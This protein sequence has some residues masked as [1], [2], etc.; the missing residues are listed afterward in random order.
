VAETIAASG[1]EAER[2]QSLTDPDK[3]RARG[4]T[5]RAVLA[6]ATARHH[7]SVAEAELDIDYGNSPIVMGDRHVA[8]SPG[9]RLPDTIEIHLVSGEA[10]MLPGLFCRAGHTAVILGGLCTA[11]GSHDSTAPIRL[12]RVASL[13]E[14]TVVITARPEDR[15]PCAWIAPDASNQLGIGEIT[16]L[17]VR[18]DGHV[19]LLA[20]RDHLAALAAYQALLVSGM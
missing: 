13:V 19:G 3:R 4:E 9:Q 6:D 12:G 10:R 16:L 15:N 11:I 14:E 2:A 5:L 1:D 8:L 17:V 20:D 7:E 18:P